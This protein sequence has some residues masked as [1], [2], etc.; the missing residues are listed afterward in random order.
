MVIT[1]SKL[2]VS[3]YGSPTA[4]VYEL[5]LLCRTGLHDPLFI[6]MWGIFFI[7]LRF[8]KKTLSHFVLSILSLRDFSLSML[9]FTGRYARWLG[10]KT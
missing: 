7:S 8:F 10:H 6:G 5:F 2:F 9:S 4:L 1:L 3:A